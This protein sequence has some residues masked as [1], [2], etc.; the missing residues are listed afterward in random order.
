[1]PDFAL[2]DGD[3][4]SREIVCAKCDVVYVKAI[5][6]AYDGLCCLFSDGG[7]AIVLA[8]PC[9][10]EAE[11]DRLVNDVIE[12]FADRGRPVTTHKSMP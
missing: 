9:G 11:L 8:A 2:I 6:M 4:I 5:A 1:M 7:G 3:M 12:E 10:R